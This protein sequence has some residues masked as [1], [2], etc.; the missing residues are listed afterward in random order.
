M[1]VINSTKKRT[2]YITDDNKLIAKRCTRCKQVKDINE[3]YDSNKNS[4]GKQSHCKQCYSETR[5]L[6]YRGNKDE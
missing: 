4:T 2:E 1:L 3:F 5:K 6:K